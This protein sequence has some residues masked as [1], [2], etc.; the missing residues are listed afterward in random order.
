MSKRKRIKLVFFIIGFIFLSMNF[1][2]AVEWMQ[3]GEI[4]IPDRTS[5]AIKIDGDLNEKAWSNAPISK[6]FLTFYP[7]Y[8]DK[9]EQKTK[10]W[11]V[12]DSQN[13]YFGFMCYDTEP[14]KIKTSI[15]QRDKMYNV[16]D[17]VGV[18]IDSMG[19][20]QTCFE[21]YVNPSG[22]QTDFLNSASGGNNMEADFIWESA[23]KI[24]SEGYQVEM[25]IPLESIRFKS[26]KEVKMGVFFSRHISRLGA[27]GAWPEVKAGHTGFHAMVTAIYRGL[28]N[29][30]KLEVLPNFTYSRNV[31]RKSAG[32]WWENKK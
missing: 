16:D 24:T 26:G 27:V 13:L 6:E 18:I 19:N 9:L 22:I 20:K 23:S 14:N 11:M 7:V 4:I 8:G 21:F 32:K 25:C 5:E 2:Q 17:W 3:N 12:Y 1:A 15:C 29:R 31:E 30:L 28:K 10:I